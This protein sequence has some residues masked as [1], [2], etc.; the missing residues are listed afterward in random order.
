[1]QNTRYL[2]KFLFHFLEM[3][4]KLFLLFHH[5]L[6]FALL[7]VKVLFLPGDL[8]QGL[9]FGEKTPP[10]PVPQ[11]QVREAVALD[12][13]DGPKLVLALGEVP[14]AGRKSG[15]DY[16]D[17]FATSFIFEQTN[18][19]CAILVRGRPFAETIGLLLSFCDEIMV[20]TSQ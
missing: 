1:M 14:G 8:Q 13:A 7:R 18:L 10:G 17:V 4:L 20:R 9:D 11:L 12:H 2:C 3:F 19:A 16:V 15:R 5:E 6:Q